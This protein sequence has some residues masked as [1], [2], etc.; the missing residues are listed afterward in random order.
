MEF[1][2]EETKESSENLLLLDEIK[3]EVAKNNNII[4][5][6]DDPVLV[7]ATILN[8][9]I[10]KI[11]VNEE[12]YLNALKSVYRDC[13]RELGNNIAVI[14]SESLKEATKEFIQFRTT[15]ILATIIITLL[16]LLNIVMA[17]LG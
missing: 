2:D 6:D 1:I 11:E 4:I 5:P 3:A 16:T 14:S 9:F 13:A 7:I 15:I 12:K 17:V 8:T 10:K